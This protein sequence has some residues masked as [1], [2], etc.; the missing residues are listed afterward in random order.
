MESITPG[1]ADNTIITAGIAT[2]SYD[3]SGDVTD[4]RRSDERQYYLSEYWYFATS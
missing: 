2:I 1:Y 3:L 4:I